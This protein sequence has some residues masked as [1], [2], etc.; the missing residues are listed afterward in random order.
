MHIRNI[1]DHTKCADSPLLISFWGRFAQTPPR[2]PVA[3][4]PPAGASPSLGAD[5]LETTFDLVSALKDQLSAK[6]QE[7][8][9]LRV[10]NPET[11]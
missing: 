9:S 2:P 7:I 6:D 1:W 5:K 11:L 10:R 3:V 4:S 8:E